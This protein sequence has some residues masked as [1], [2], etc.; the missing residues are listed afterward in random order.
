MAGMYRIGP[1]DFFTPGD[2][3]ADARTL[4]DQINNLDGQNWDA[5]SQSLFSAFQ[6]FLSEWRSF[7]SSNFGGFFT[8][9]ATA[10]NDSNRDQLIQFENRYTSFVNQYR[11]ESGNNIP[12][13]V[14][15]STGAQDTIGAQLLNQLQPLIP[16]FN[17]KNVLIVVGIGAAVIGV[18]VFRRPL[19]NLLSKGVG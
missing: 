17:I 13:V 7:Y 12:D 16:Q 3:A 5:P 8:N 15:P 1:S 4:N 2:L 14:A 11:L 18:I 9:L 10:L 19:M 6:S